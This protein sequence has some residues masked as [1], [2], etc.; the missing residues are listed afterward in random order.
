[1]IKFN[2]HRHLPCKAALFSFL[3]DTQ[4]Q[5]VFPTQSEKN[6]I[7]MTSTRNQTSDVKRMILHV[8]MRTF[9]RNIIILH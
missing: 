6:V 3:S 2:E 1:M 8:C 7:T 5:P 9:D 4:F